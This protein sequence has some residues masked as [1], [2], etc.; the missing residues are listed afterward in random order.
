[1]ANEYDILEQRAGVATI[2]LRN[3]VLH[4]FGDTYGHRNARNFSIKKI[5]GNQCTRHGKGAENP[6]TIRQLPANIE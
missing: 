3:F 6:E 2:T 1:M 4:N 5:L